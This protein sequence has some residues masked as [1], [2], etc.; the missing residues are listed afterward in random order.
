[1]EKT[2]LYFSP[3]L[4]RALREAAK[5]AGRSQADIVRD[6]VEQYLSRIDRPL[7]KSVGIGADGRLP[8]SELEAWLDREWGRQ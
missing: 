6:A 1:M 7:L 2:T 5:R 8:A 4:H 3:A